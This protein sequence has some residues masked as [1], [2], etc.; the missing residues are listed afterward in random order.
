MMRPTVYIFS[1]ELDIGD[2]EIAIIA[3]HLPAERLEKANRYLRA[4]DRNNCMISY[5]L[6]LYGLLENY[7]IKA[8]PE[9]AIGTHGK[10]YFTDADI[11]FSISHCDSG[12]CCGISDCSIGVDIQDTDIE[13]E[14]ILDL[15]M[16]Q[17]EK[18]VIVRSYAPAEDF[19]RLWSLKE[20]ICKY[21]GTG[22]DDSLNKLDFSEAGEDVFSIDG[23][24]FR[25]ENRGDFC[26]SACTENQA[27]VFIEKNIEQY[28]HRFLQMYQEENKKYLY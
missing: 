4:V 7:G 10:P 23:V 18:E 24:V 5:F 3:S 26:I 25:S 17:R 28:I 13:F 27:P 6:L 12:V 2:E 14:E 20:C 8:V 22:I 15:A 9:T 19:A 21:R 1:N 16:S 11:F